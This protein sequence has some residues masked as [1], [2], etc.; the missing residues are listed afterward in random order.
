MS[1]S[2]VEVRRVVESVLQFSDLAMQALDADELNASDQKRLTVFLYL[3]GAVN[4][5][6]RKDSLSPP[7]VHAVSLA[8]F[9]SVFDMS[10]TESARVSQW[11]IDQTGGGSSW[12]SVIHA[13]LDAFLR[14]KDGE[15]L[16]PAN[17]LTA[18]VRTAS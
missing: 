1:A 9:Q 11:C 3:F 17:D 6:A 7:Q 18:C 5:A 8:L 15:L 13:G 14:W 12:K 10:S 2:D 16:N 4:G